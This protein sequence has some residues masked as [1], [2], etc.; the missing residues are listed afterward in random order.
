MPALAAAAKALDSIKQ[1]DVAELRTIKKFHDDV[2]RVFKGVCVLLGSD[3][4]KQMNQETQKR[5]ENWEIPSK[6]LLSD[7]TFLKQLQTYDKDNMDAKRIEKIQ[8]FITHEFCTVAHLKNINAVASSLCAWVLAMDKYYRVSLVV[9][10][11]KES[12]AIAEKEYAEL[13]AALNEKKENLRVVQERVARLQAQL[14]AAQDEKRDLEAKVADCI[15]R[16]DK[17]QKLIEL[18]GGQKARWKQQSEELGLVYN[19]LTGDVLCSSGIIAYLGAFDSL[20]RNELLENWVKL[21]AE[22]QIPSSGNFSLAK[23]LG[24]AVRIQHWCIDGLPS[25]NFSVENA[26]ITYKTSRWPLYIDPQGQANK[27]IKTMNKKT[28]KGMKVLKFSDD[29]YLKHLEASIQIGCPVMI[30]NVG[31]ELDPAIEPLLQK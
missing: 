26:I 24:D 29:S 6:K 2:L 15:A 27:W 4:V 31:V 7:L 14:K 1:S 12:L 19:G 11:K 3:A 30:E 13:N 10:P 8:P 25:D 23:T 18:L 28:E 5:E 22:K 17:A 21:S 20:Y 16:L 9:K